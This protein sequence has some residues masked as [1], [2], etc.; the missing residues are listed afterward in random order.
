MDL[1]N[2]YVQ[3]VLKILGEKQ[4][5]AEKIAQLDKLSETLGLTAH[6]LAYLE[7]EFEEGIR[8][9]EGY[10]RYKQWDK[11]ITELEQ[12]V[13]LKPLHTEAIYQTALAYTQKYQDSRKEEDRQKALYYADRA[14]QT[15]AGKEE[16]L[17]IIAKLDGKWI[18]W[19]SWALRHMAW[20]ICAIA[21]VICGGLMWWLMPS[22][23]EILKQE[24]EDNQKQN[25]PIELD[26]ELQALGANIALEASFVRAGKEGL[27]YHLR[28][29]LYSTKT[30]FSQIDW[31]LEV[32]DRAGKL[33]KTQ[34]IQGLEEQ[35]FELRPQDYLPIVGQVQLFQTARVGKA[36]IANKKIVH[37]EKPSIYEPSKTL[38][39]KN[40][41]KIAKLGLEVAERYQTIKPAPDYFEHTLCL[42][43]RH[44]SAKPLQNWRVELQ[45]QDKQDRLIHTETITLIQPQEPLL[46]TEK[47]RSQTFQFKI[48]L[49]QKD[50][51]RY[52]I[53]VLKAE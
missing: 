27:A 53:L 13:L 15:D 14:L 29:H 48:P 12:A 16:A 10:M 40:D 47:W 3:H 11:A 17:A 51:S 35:Q 52:Q 6:D 49:K 21:L 19:K 20:L 26:N 18:K 24:I 28:A 25:V 8:R 2:K 33:L 9:G 32:Y 43:Y 30:E 41:E 45:W 50:F 46:K 7:R 23:K 4:A 5:T 31:Q 42:A 39:L 34:E 38:P 37:Q 1:V 22:D 44:H 36:R